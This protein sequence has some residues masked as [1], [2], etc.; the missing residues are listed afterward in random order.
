MSLVK[1]GESKIKFFFL[2]G[3]PKYTLINN[4]RTVNSKIEYI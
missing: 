3:N 4:K 2:Q 1:L